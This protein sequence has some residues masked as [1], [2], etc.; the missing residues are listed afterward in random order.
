MSAD[1]IFLLFVSVGGAGFFL[2]A[3]FIYEPKQRKEI[4]HM[5]RLFECSMTK[6]LLKGEATDSQKMILGEIVQ[7]RPTIEGWPEWQEVWGGKPPI[8]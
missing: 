3:K 2:W 5:N 8:R 6:L 4:Q 1:L 7:R